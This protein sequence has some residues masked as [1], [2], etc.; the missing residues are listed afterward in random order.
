MKY[1]NIYNYEHTLISIGLICF[2]YKFEHGGCEVIY[3]VLIILSFFLYIYRWYKKTRECMSS[4][5]M[6]IHLPIFIY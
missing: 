6:K 2:V 1:T 5:I 4:P 3:F